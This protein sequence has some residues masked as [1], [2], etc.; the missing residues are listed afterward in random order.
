MCYC[1]YFHS[2]IWDLA[3]YVK[4]VNFCFFSLQIL[5][6]PWKCIFP[7]C[8]MLHSTQQ[9]DDPGIERANSFCGIFS[10]VQHDPCGLFHTLSV[11]LAHALK[12]IKTHYFSNV[13]EAFLV[14]VWQNRYP[15][16]K[17]LYFKY[18][19]IFFLRKN[20]LLIIMILMPRKK[21][22]WF[23]ITKGWKIANAYFWGRV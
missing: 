22:V 1:L 18:N 13:K 4:S 9:K 14:H 7:S 8:Q 5:D 12:N 23:Y 11:H 20:M 21:M 10:L 3:L 19:T 15:I 2:E 6:I 16:L 17:L